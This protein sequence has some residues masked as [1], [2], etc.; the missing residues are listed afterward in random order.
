M[1]LKETYNKIAESWHQDHQTDDW[2]VEGTDKFISCLK[3]GDRVV[4]VGC[5]SGTKSK[6]LLKNGLKVLGIDFSEKM[7]EIA[8]K[9]NP[10]ADFLVMDL[11]HID[12]LKEMYDGVF[13]QAVLLH[14][15]KKD[16]KD[17]VKKLWCII[18]RNGYI[19]VA[20]KEKKSEGPEEEIKVDKDYG[21]EYARFF[22]YFT[23]GEVKG[24]IKDLGVEIV[25]EHVT[26][27]GNTR[28]IQVIG[29][30]V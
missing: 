3:P 2:W 15:P 5:G 27:S 19:Y 14:V 30:K 24:L 28:W 1:N 9:E 22:S 17:A 29:K 21:H 13:A 18:K 4:D 11:Y 25:Y 12:G 10:D 20:V 8:K 7:V 23:I 26:P 16:V 6:Y